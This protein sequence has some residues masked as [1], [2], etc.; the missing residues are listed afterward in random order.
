MTAKSSKDQSFYHQKRLTLGVH[1]FLLQHGISLKGKRIVVAVSGG[2]D[3]MLLLWLALQFKNLDLCSEIVAAHVHHGVRE[4]SDLDWQLVTTFCLENDIP[5]LGYRLTQL[6]AQSKNFENKARKLRHLWLKSQLKRGDQL[7]MGHH[8]DDSFEW[9]MLNQFRSS[10][11]KPHVGIPLVNGPVVRPFMTMSR[12]QIEGWVDYLKLPFNEDQ[13]NKDIRFE[14]N[15]IRQML[16][17][18]IKKRYPQYL[19]HYVHSHRLLAQKLHLHLASSSINEVK[20][21]DDLI[22]GTWIEVFNLEDWNSQEQ[23][24]AE[25]IYRYSTKN[26][27]TIR[28]E[29]TKLIEALKSSKRGPHLFSGNVRVFMFH[30]RALVVGERQFLQW[31]LHDQYL[32]QQFSDEKNSQVSDSLLFWDSKLAKSSHFAKTAQ[33]KKSLSLLPKFSELLLR[34]GFRVWSGPRLQFE[35]KRQKVGQI[36]LSLKSLG[37]QFSEMTNIP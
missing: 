23:N 20:I 19:K 5:F 34:R 18:L 15:F 9:T 21:Y 35:Q 26:R 10:E 31:Q 7:W 33:I 36:P 3:S 8:I 1:H 30:D 28:L 16:V 11:L 17:P 37:N 24:L 29:L 32:C 25:I 14:R 13:S 4:D 22:G 27:G 6:E 12:A 2:R